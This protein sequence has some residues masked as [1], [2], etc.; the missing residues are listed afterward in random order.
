LR[1]H[2]FTSI[3]VIGGLLTATSVLWEYARMNPAY[4]SLVDPWSIRGFESVHGAIAVAI[5]LGL[6]VLAAATKWKRSTEPRIALIIVGTTVVVAAIFA[7]AFDPGRDFAFDGAL[8]VGNAFLLSMITM[9]LAQRRLS[10]HLPFG[11]KPSTSV[12]FGVWAASFA[13][14]GA[15]LL[16][17]T[18][19]VSVGFGVAVT[20]VFLLMGGLSL[21]SA[22]LELAAAR[23]MIYA[24]LVAGAAIGLSGGAI[25]STLIRLQSGVES[26]VGFPAQYKDT[27]VTWGWFLANIGIGLVF[28]GAVGLWGRRRDALHDAARLAAQR[29]AA[30]ASAAEIQAARAKIGL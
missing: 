9:R 24:S 4:R 13:I 30:E 22:P 25:R 7:F 17:I 26:T 11:S 27:Q 19:D 21:A 2:I 15:L 16:A 1:R 3:G 29:A 10:R 20:L 18:A 6:A 23:I 28:I 5:G 14:F 8:A 12:S